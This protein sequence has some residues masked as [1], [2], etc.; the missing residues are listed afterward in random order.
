MSFSHNRPRAANGVAA[1]PEPVR[2]LLGLG[3]DYLRWVSL[4]PMVV[5]WALFL[6]MVIFFNYINIEDSID[7]LFDGLERGYEIYSERFGPIAWIEANEEAYRQE[8]AERELDSTTPESQG[9]V[10][11]GLSDL[12]PFIMKAWGV[13]ALAAWLL[14]LLRNLVFGPRPPRTL[15]QKIRIMIMAV[16]AGWALLFVAYFFGR[17]AYEGSFFGWFALFSGVAVIVTFI[18]A[19]TLILGEGMDFFRRRLDPAGT[20]LDRA[21]SRAQ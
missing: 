7:S 2:I 16:L 12:T 6:F 13:I 4:T 11:F 21:S 17:S 5:A 18:S 8:Q 14:S 15:A 3:L 19:I 9:P 20:R 1:I 10:E